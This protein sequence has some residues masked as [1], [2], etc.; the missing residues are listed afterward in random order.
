MIELNGYYY[1]VSDYHKVI[2]NTKIW[3]SSKYVDGKT[4]SDGALIG[5][6]YYYFDADGKMVY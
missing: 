3:L 4:F 5:V 6:G 2:T 1:F